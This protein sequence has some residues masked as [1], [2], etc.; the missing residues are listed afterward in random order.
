[1]VLLLALY[2]TGSLRPGT[3]SFWQQLTVLAVTYWRQLGKSKCRLEEL[4]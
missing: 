3:V 1:M 4:R 2:E